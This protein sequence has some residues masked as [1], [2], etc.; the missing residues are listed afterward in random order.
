MTFGVCPNCENKVDVGVEPDIGIHHLC[1]TCQVDLVIVWLN[2]IELSIIDYEDY[3]QFDD[4]SYGDVFQKIKK[5]K[6]VYNG[7]GKTQKK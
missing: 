1:E 3:G 7:N 6:G 4:D 2:P 5:K